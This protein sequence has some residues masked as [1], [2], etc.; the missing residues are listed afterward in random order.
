MYTRHGTARQDFAHTYC[1]LLC[2][3]RVVQ[4]AG[5]PEEWRIVVGMEKY[6]VFDSEEVLVPATYHYLP[7]SFR[8]LCN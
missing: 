3:G 5:Y 7:L 2:V 4:D 1:D 6:S 8:W